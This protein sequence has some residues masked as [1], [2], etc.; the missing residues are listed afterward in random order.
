M[1]LDPA[2]AIADLRELAA[3]TG[4]PDGARRVCWTPEWEVAREFLRERLAS[5][6]G[7]VEVSVDA[8]GNLWAVVSGSTE[9]T[10]ALGSHVDSVP[11][12]GWLDGALG[13]MAALEVL[14]GVAAAGSPPPRT[15]ALVDWADEEGA[16]FGRSL[17]GSSAF[18]GSLDVEA[19]RGLR[20][21]DGVAL[22]DAL[23]EHGVE[24]EQMP[25]AGD[26]R[27]ESLCAYLELHIEQGPVLEEE[28]QPCAAVVGCVGVERHRVTFSGR[29]AHAGT[30]PMD[31]RADA[32]VAAARVILGLPGIAERHGGVCTAGR[33]DMEPGIAT[34]V[35][36]RAELV[37]DQRHLDAGA[38]AAMLADA[39]SLWESAAAGGNCSVKAERIWSIE[40]V[41]FHPG[42][43]AAASEACAAAGGRDE[44][45]PSG[46]LH[47]AAELAR[48]VP[49]AMVFSSSVGGVSHSPAEDTPEADL[50]RALEAYGALASRVIEEGVPS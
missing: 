37:V 24:L 29:A 7:A 15:V 46:A 21:A 20:D 16:R 38:L 19:V 22:D 48:V 31:R 35:P 39:A 26:G 44:P 9:D 50:E 3:R 45:M 41:P 34:A 18:A 17:L 28:R 23:R 1:D 10:V 32:G 36:G 5:L 49:A 2:R 43:V 6:G 4:G 11:A 42:L 40:P 12:G 25:S 33:L 47:D 8:A 14:R 13:V 27:L 30:T